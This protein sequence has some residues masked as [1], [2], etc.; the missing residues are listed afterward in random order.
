MYIKLQLKHQ[1]EKEA[2]YPL[3]WRETFLRKDD[4][5]VDSSHNLRGKEE[6]EAIYPLDW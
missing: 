5:A 6:K 2:I 1:E 4:F 3:D